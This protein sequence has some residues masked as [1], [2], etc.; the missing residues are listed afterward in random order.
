MVLANLRL[1]KTHIL[2]KAALNSDAQAYGGEAEGF[3]IPV[4]TLT[5]SVLAIW[6]PTWRWEWE[7]E[8]TIS[9]EES[10]SKMQPVIE[11]KQLKDSGTFW[12]RHGKEHSW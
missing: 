3:S 1:R 6:Q 9:V 8:S 2:L 7:V 4:E 12:T 5:M 10:A 11:S